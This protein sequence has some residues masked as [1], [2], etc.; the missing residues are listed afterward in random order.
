MKQN[1]RKKAAK[2]NITEETRRIMRG[3][4]WADYKLYDHFKTKFELRLAEYGAEKMDG[5][6]K[7]LQRANVKLRKECVKVIA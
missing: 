1:E 5:R 6:K 3:W 7:S 4:L 2:S